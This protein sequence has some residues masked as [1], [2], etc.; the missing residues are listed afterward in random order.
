MAE[1]RLPSDLALK[2]A[3]K[4][5]LKNDKPLMLDYWLKSVKK[6]IVIGVRGTGE[7]LL[8]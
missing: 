8:V 2:H 1:E 7:K 3:C 5:S 6:E 4:L